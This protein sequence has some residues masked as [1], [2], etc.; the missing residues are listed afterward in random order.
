M[1]CVLARQL[2]GEQQRVALGTQEQLRGRAGARG[3]ITSMSDLLKDAIAALRILPEERQEAA[4]RVM[5]AY[6][7]YEDDEIDGR[8][9]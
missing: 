4:V 8:S 2:P 6:A 1:R 9:S 5:L 3:T 7:L